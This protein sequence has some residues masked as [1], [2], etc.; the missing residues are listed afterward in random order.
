MTRPD[1]VDGAVGASATGLTVFETGAEERGQVQRQLGRCILRLQ[2]YEMQSKAILVAADVS[3]SA[4]TWQARLAAR[5]KRI[6]KLTLGELVKEM[7]A[8]WLARNDVP[9]QQD[10]SD[11]PADLKEIW[12]RRRSRHEMDPA[13]YLRTIAAMKELVAMRNE[14]FHHFLERFNLFET[15]GCAEAARHLQESYAIIDGHMNELTAWAS[16][17]DKACEIWVQTLASDELQDALFDELKAPAAPPPA[18][19]PPA[20]DFSSICALLRAADTAHAVDGWVLLVQAI[21]YINQASKH[22]E[23]HSRYNCKRWRQALER[24]NAFEIK[25]RASPDRPTTLMAYRSKSRSAMP[26]A[27]ATGAHLRTGRAAS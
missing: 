18:A 14:T 6:S 15:R 23:F 2:Q 20:T 3:G 26:M 24:S 1:Q 5:R 27:Y 13:A 22:T 8:S 11:A 19:V 16:H 9:A 7:Q 12:F 4:S 17:M 25:E 10:E 21:A